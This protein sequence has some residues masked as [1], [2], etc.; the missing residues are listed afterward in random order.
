MQQQCRKFTEDVIIILIVYLTLYW[1][2]GLILFNV[3][4]QITDT[5]IQQLHILSIEQ[6][7]T[8]FKTVKTLPS[9]VTS[10]QSKLHDCILLLCHL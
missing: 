6:I 3:F 8:L 10:F 5:V 1:I 7:V 4:L 2:L 9:K